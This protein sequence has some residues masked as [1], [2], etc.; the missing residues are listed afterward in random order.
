VTTISEMAIASI[1][2]GERVR[3]DMGDIAALSASIGK[4]GLLHPPAVTS[5]GLLIA[6]HRRI[7]AC[8]SLGMETIPVRIIDV[9]DLL[10]AER[11]ENEVRKAFT[12]SEAVAIARVIEDELKVR[13]KANISNG[14]KRK[15]ALKKG[16]ACE[17]A[18][19][20]NSL[21]VKAM[22]SASAAVGMCPQR[23]GQ[24]KEIV[25]AAEKDAEKFGDIVETMDATNNVNGAYTELRRRRD[26]M[27]A[28]HAVLK[29]MAHRDPNKEIQRAITSLDGL[30]IGIER[31]DIT[32]LDPALVDGWIAELK[33]HASSINRFIRSIH[34]EFS[35]QA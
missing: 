23:Y 28:R 12:P 11:D 26:K 8:S 6:G 33:G 14:A 3:K 25:E 15:W 9:G 21:G 16:E 1:S 4:H 35:H 30:V 17:F 29:K 27:P 2:I 31:I 18:E 34:H 7:L 19:S 10:S 24:A 22:S 32:N 13:A 5:D 20:A